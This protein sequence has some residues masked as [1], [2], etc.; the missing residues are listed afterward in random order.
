M[1][2]LRIKMWFWFLIW[3]KVSLA[4][5]FWM[6]LYIYILILRSWKCN[7]KHCQWFYAVSKGTYL[8]LHFGR[9]RFR[10]PQWQIWHVMAMH[11]SFIFEWG[12]L[13]DVYLNLVDCCWLKFESNAI[14]GFREWNEMIKFDWKIVHIWKIMIFR[15]NIQWS[16]IIISIRYLRNEKIAEK[17]VWEDDSVWMQKNKLNGI[18]IISA[19][20]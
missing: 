10:Q 7:R 12:N 9:H 16:Y 1:K 20:Y 3:S 19:A 18:V 11:F 13:S 15:H 17:M 14:V 8:L 5:P 2:I 4:F 6:Y